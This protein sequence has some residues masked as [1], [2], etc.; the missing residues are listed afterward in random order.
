MKTA[1]C[2]RWKSPSMSAPAFWYFATRKSAELAGIDLTAG[3][4]YE[5]SETQVSDDFELEDE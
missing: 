1:Y 2:L 4:T 3:T 5:I